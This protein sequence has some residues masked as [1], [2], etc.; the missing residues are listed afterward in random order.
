MKPQKQLLRHNPPATFGDCYRTS[1]AVILDM[2]AADVPHFMDVGNSGEGAWDQAETWLNARGLCTIAMLFDGATPLQKVLDTIA[3]V[4]QRSRPAF[5]LHGTSRNR[6]NHTVV[7]CNGDIVC[8]P[9][10][11]NSGIIGPCDDGYYW[12]TFISSLASTDSAAKRE[13]AAILTEAAE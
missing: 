2:D 10:L 11:D 13:A 12:V 7:A 4:N 8:D 9:S 5:L 6:V 1:I 3:C